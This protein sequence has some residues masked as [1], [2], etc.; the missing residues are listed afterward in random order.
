MTRV[1]DGDCSSGTA[2]VTDSWPAAARG[3]ASAHQAAN[4][5]RPVGARRRILTMT[6]SA[7]TRGDRSGEM[8]A[9]KHRRVDGG[10]DTTFAARRC[11]WIQ[12]STASVRMTQ[13]RQFELVS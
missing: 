9:G 6:L 3:N 13:I 1:G 2:H 12:P 10:F 5:C 4:L 8:L 7:R 11:A